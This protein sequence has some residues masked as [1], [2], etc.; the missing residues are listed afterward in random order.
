[1]L[2]LHADGLTTHPDDSNFSCSIQKPVSK[3]WQLYPGCYAISNQIICCTYNRHKRK[4]LISTS[5]L[6]AYEASVATSLYSAL[7]HAS[8]RIFVLVFSLSFTTKKVSPSSSIRRFANSFWQASAEVHFSSSA[9]AVGQFYSLDFHTVC[10]VIKS[11]PSF[12]QHPIRYKLD[13]FKTHT[14]SYKAWH[15]E[16]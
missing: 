5:S 7:W 12:V 2:S 15:T 3:S 8:T 11:L 4:Y 6:L 1:M 16:I 9:L 10:N 13:W 14:S